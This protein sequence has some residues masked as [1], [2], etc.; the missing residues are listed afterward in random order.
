MRPKA[1]FLTSLLAFLT[2]TA[3]ATPLIPPVLHLQIAASDTEP[4][5]DLKVFAGEFHRVDY[6]S[7]KDAKLQ[8]IYWTPKESAEFSKFLADRKLATKGK[9]TLAAGSPDAA[10]VSAEIKNRVLTPASAKA[11]K[12]ND[13][14][15]KLEELK[16]SDQKK[17][18]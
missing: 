9:V 11:K 5:Q 17:R 15:K 18:E 10:A 8:Q 14:Q 13:I 16:K 1:L 4:A 6:T 12:D 2:L 3:A 7:G